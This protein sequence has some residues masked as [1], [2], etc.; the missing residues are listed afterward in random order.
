MSKKKKKHKRG[1]KSRHDTDSEEDDI[2]VLQAVSSAY[3]VPEVNS[4]KWVVLL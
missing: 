4:S 1:K 2:P 3:D